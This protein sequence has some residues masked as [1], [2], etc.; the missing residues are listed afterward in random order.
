MSLDEIQ[1]KDIEYT[2]EAIHEIKQS[3][4]DI[5]NEIKLLGGVFMRLDVHKQMETETNK[6]ISKLEKNMS[7][8]FRTTGGVV[9]ATVIGALFS[10]LK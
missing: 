1:Q 2:R 6:R 5:Q 7:W 3:L 4:R 10:L 9:I 8:I